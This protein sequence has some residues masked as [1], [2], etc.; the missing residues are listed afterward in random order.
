MFLDWKKKLKQ[1]KITKQWN[2]AYGKS[3]QFNKEKLY[4]IL[5]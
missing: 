3:K 5:R 1:L 4:L 2:I